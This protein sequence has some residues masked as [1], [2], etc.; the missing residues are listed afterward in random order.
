MF[1]YEAAIM[2]RYTARCAFIIRACRVA[3]VAVLFSRY[4]MLM[5]YRHSAERTIR[6]RC[7][8][9]A[10]IR[11]LLHVFALIT[12]IPRCAVSNIMLLYA[13]INRVTVKVQTAN[14]STNRN[15]NKIK[16]T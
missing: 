1:R 13:L 15:V 12:P 11:V 3:R 5:P 9:K 8:I 16:I 4:A 7:F 14:K 2:I 6:Y 10:T